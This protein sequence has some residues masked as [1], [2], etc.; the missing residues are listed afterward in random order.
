MFRALSKP[1]SRSFLLQTHMKFLLLFVIG[2]LIWTNDDARTFTADVLQ[3]ASEVVR[4]EPKSL[5]E[6]I[7]YV[8]K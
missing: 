6:R 8:L 7:N 3:D 1:R 2:A 5:Q 4:P